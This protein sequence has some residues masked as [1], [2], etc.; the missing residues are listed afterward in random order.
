MPRVAVLAVDGGNSKTDVLLVD[1]RGEVLASVRG[2]GA[3]AQNV[4]MASSMAALDKLVRRAARQVGV[5]DTRDLAE[6]TAAYLAGADFPREEAALSRA[7]EDLGWSR[8]TVVGNDTF[9]VLRAGTPDG[10]GVAVV[11]GAGINCVG[12][13]PDGRTSRFPSVG[14]ISGDWGGGSF[15]ATEALWWAV[16]AADGRGPATALLPAV[17]EHFALPS[18]GELIERLH[19]GEIPWDELHALCPLLFRV[20]AEGDPVAGRLVDRLV[21]EVTLMV[22]VTLRRLDLLDEPVRVVLGGG[23]AVGAGPAL[24]GRIAL[25]CGERAPRCEVRV[26]DVPPVVGAALLG[27]DALGA[28]REAER[29]LRAAGAALLANPTPAA[30]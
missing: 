29:R 23:V 18:T 3:S 4:G 10:L 7:L 14:R 9:A 8:S 2:P 25:A 12:V 22:T 16:R 13:A 20:A 28:D 11:L 6:H 21:E 19:F 15:L 27:L 5:A 24:T 17:L 30:S 26:V 1:A